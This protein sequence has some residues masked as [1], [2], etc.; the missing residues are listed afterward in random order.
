[1]R[2]SLLPTT[3]P[4]LTGVLSRYGDLSLLRL[5]LFLSRDLS[6]D[7]LRLKESRLESLRPGLL[8]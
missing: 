1:M 2:T 6:R 3:S 8:E 5:S 4:H 7:L